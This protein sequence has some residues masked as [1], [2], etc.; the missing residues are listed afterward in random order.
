VRRF[1]ASRRHPHFSAGRLAPALEA[2]GISYRH[3]PGLGGHRQPTPDSGNLWW[4]IPAFRGYAD[5]MASPEFAAAL[6]GLVAE[7]LLLPTVILCAEAQP[8]RCHRQLVADA[9]VARGA[10]VRHIV[11]RGLVTD[12]ALNERA[13]I[14]PDGRLV[15]PAKDQA[16]LF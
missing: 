9:L 4:R 16:S 13:R 14:A 10:R 12:H 7:A 1:P 15:Y 3:E 5:Y 8:T 2:S 6:Q 11:E